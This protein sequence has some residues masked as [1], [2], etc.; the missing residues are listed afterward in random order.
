LA[1][2]ASSVDRTDFT[3]TEDE[4]AGARRQLSAD[5]T[6]NAMAQADAI[7]KAAGMRVVSVR[8]IEVDEA[9]EALGK[10]DRFFG[11]GLAML[12]GGGGGAPMPLTDTAAGEEELTETVN[13]V[14]AAGPLH[15]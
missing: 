2:G 12:A 3:P 1:N 4:I 15:P 5:A 8:D 9:G 6:R 7:A 13:L 11:G 14:A 10:A